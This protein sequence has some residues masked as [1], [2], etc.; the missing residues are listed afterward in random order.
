MTSNKEDRK[1]WARLIQKIY[2]VDP[3]TCPERGPL[4][5]DVEGCHGPMRVISFIEDQD[6]IKKTLKHLGLWEV[7]PRPPPRMPKAQPLYTEPYIDYSDSQVPPSDN[8]LFHLT[9]I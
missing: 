1:N 7:N 3:L 9:L 6:I 8:G 2:E 4:G 5:S